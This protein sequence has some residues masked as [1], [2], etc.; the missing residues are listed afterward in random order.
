MTINNQVEKTKKSYANKSYSVAITVSAAPDTNMLKAP[1]PVVPGGS[2]EYK[3]TVTNTGN[4]TL[5]DLRVVDF[6]YT[7]HLSN[8]SNTAVEPPE[9][10]ITNNSTSDEID[11]LIASLAAGASA[12]ITFDVTVASGLRDGTVIENVAMVNSNGINGSKISAYSE[13]IITVGENIVAQ[14]SENPVII[15]TV[16]PVMVV[17]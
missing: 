7:P 15:T 6:L 8:I 4:V 14:L 12:T 2:V 16:D 1:N 3:I 17:V 11:I 10:S 5:T 13:K 9:L